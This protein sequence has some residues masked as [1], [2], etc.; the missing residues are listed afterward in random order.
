MDAAAAVAANAKAR[1]TTRR[2]KVICL[3]LG[4]CLRVE[5]I[6]TR[7]AARVVVKPRAVAAARDQEEARAPGR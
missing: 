6:N 2:R 3:I 7:R 4:L 5:C 1:T